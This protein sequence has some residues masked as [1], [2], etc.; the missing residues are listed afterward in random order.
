MS[1]LRTVHTAEGGVVVSG[2]QR[3]RPG[4]TDPFFYLAEIFKMFYSVY[5]TGNHEQF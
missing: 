3:W 1:I 4:G 5:F 2:D